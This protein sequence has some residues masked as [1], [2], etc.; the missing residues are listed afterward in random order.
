MI[1]IVS[2]NDPSVKSFGQDV[3]VYSDN[4]FDVTYSNNVYYYLFNNEKKGFMFAEVAMASRACA[5]MRVYNVEYNVKVNE[6]ASLRD[7]VRN[8]SLSIFKLNE[9]PSTGFMVDA[10]VHELDKT[11]PMK[12]G[13]EIKL[14][15]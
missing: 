2:C 1:A 8:D 3:K 14:T 12:S 5:Q 6:Q 4:P 15:G 9:N 11:Q 13:L 10:S 7:F